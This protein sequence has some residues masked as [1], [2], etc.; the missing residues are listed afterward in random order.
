MRWEPDRAGT[1]LA[2]PAEDPGKLEFADAATVSA[3]WP[4][5]HEQVRQTRAG[6]VSARPGP[7]V[8]KAANTNGARRFVMHCAADGTVDGAATY[9]LPGHPTWPRELTP[10][11]LARATAM[12]AEP[13]AP[14]NPIGF[15]RGEA[16][17]AP[18]RPG[19]RAR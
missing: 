19:G 5:L 4:A 3:A 8:G 10:G 2:R 6:M 15:Q 9:R 7:W 16:S 13:D 1:R 11:A 12:L 14:F 18:P 17:A